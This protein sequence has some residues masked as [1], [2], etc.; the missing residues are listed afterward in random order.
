MHL[1]VLFLSALAKLLGVVRVTSTFLGLSL[2]STSLMRP[3]TSRLFFFPS[4]CP[5]QNQHSTKGLIHTFPLR[6]WGRFKIRKLCALGREWRSGFQHV[7]RGGIMEQWKERGLCS[8]ATLK[9]QSP[10]LPLLVVDCEKD[11]S[12]VALSVLIS[13]LRIWNLRLPCCSEGWI[14]SVMSLVHVD[15]QKGRAC[16]FLSSFPIYVITRSLW[17]MVGP[18]ETSVEWTN[19]MVAVIAESLL[20]AKLAYC[21]SSFHRQ[22]SGAGGMRLISWDH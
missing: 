15:P 1:L 20:C 6:N 22:K 8:H 3:G 14:T 2:L 7:L 4:F 18:Q 16:I 21:L 17:S 9:V 5:Q 19:E 11:T 10:G 12:S 13:K